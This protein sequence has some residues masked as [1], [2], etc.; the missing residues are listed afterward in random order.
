M[1]GFIDKKELIIGFAGAMNLISPEMQN[2]HE[3]VAYLAYRLAEEMEIDE[4][5]RR[6]IFFGAL[7]H[8]IG[9]V[10]QIG[11]LSLTEI[12]QNARNVAVMGSSLLN[13]FPE[14]LPF[15]DAVGRSQTPWEIAK[16]I[17]KTLR[18][19]ARLGQIIHLADVV[20]L[21]L[22]DG[23]H[24][25]NQI[26]LILDNIKQTG[27]SEFDPE[28]MDAFERLCRKSSVWMDLLYRPQCY[29]DII[30]TDGA[31][32]I[33]ETLSLTVVM[34]KIIDFRSPF[35]AMHS[36]GVAASAES[37]AELSGM[38]EDECKMMR[39]AGN[40]HDL[41]KLRISREILEKPGKL[42]A[43]EF[44]IMKEHTYF[45]YSILSGIRG[46]EQIAEW[47]AYHHEK[48]DG[49]GYPF[50]K[51][52]REIPLG[53]RIMTVADIFS[54]I[55]EDRPYRKGMEPEKVRSILRREAEE[56]KISSTIVDLLINNYD[57]I[58]AK[59]EKESRAA[60]A[61]Y[62]KALNQEQ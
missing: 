18:L 22:D 61:T 10:M 20:T 60:S 54:A 51:Q 37:L 31:F 6:M 52:G 1:H 13:M 26:D 5:G 24:V 29:I 44:N 25:L 32:T 9:G 3:K 21:L 39:I 15:S 16:K 19:R 30:P 41:G 58:N 11:K 28:I 33:D 45:T 43:E 55:T 2:H 57:E 46:F 17:P 62:Q 59:R 40:L 38:S 12:E 7:L 42:T 35:T 4:Q 36:A 23:T 49:S 56:G 53:S 8:D 27:E 50:G 48:L 14:T 34:S 47:A